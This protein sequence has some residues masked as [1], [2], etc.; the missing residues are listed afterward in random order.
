[1]KIIL[2]DQ[3]LHRRP[4]ELGCGAENMTAGAIL[5]ALGAT[6]QGTDV[7]SVGGRRASAETPVGPHDTVQLSPLGL[8]G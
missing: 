8:Q 4:D 6:P 3:V 5:T 7:I 1:M 2:A